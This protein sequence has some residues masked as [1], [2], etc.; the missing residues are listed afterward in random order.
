MKCL[1]AVLMLG[2]ASLS[3]AA[4]EAPERL[5]V[6]ASEVVDR[7]TLKAFVEGGKEYL[8][9]IRTLT[10]TAKLRDILPI[11][12]YRERIRDFSCRG[13]DARSSECN[14]L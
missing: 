13:S 12:L 14:R 7:E 2:P 11:Y 8:E 10:E 3:P 1:I 5:K 9:S 6:T 4:T